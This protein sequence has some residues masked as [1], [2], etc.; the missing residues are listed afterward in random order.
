M[1]LKL[2]DM[3]L[4]KVTLNNGI[5][6]LR[7]SLSIMGLVGPTMLMKPEYDECIEEL[8]RDKEIIKLEFLDPESPR[9]KSIYFMKGTTFKA[10]TVQETSI[11]SPDN[12]GQL[13]NEGNKD[14]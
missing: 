13:V 1:K 2:K 12:Q 5:T 7:L 8:L 3:I 9:S 4:N 10:L 14:S 11:A 6:D